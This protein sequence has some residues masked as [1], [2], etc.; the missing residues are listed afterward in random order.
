VDPLTLYTA[1]IG[2]ARPDA[3]DVTRG[4]AEQARA[5]GR[6][7]PGEI[8]APSHAILRPALEGNRMAAQLRK[9]GK[10]EEADKIELETWA[11]YLPRYKQEMRASWVAHRAAWLELL[12]CESVT[13]LCF[14]A[15]PRRCH[16]GALASILLKVAKHQGREAR[17]AGE[18]RRCDRCKGEVLHELESMHLY[19]GGKRGGAWLTNWHARSHARPDGAPCREQPTLDLIDPEP[20]PTHRQP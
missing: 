18:W 17:Y 11:T 5:D 19:F 4:S 2:C 7:F 16:R 6:P 3:L 14:C 8:F 10:A 9:A 1:R 13:L 12:A 15:N 20:A